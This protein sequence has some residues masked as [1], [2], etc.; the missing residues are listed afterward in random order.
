[1]RDA[2]RR[3]PG[4]AHPVAWGAAALGLL[5]GMGAER[6]LMNRW[7]DPRPSPRGALLG[8]VSGT[9]SQVDGPDGTDIVVETYGP[10]D[11]PQLVLVHGW[12]CT[13]RVWHELVVRLGRRWR[14]VTYD[15]PG[16]GRSTAPVSGRYDLD[17]L[18]DTLTRVID[19]ATA[20]GPLVVV[21]HSLGGM[22]VLNALRRGSPATRRRLAGVV[23]VSTLASPRSERSWRDA[24][25]WVVSRLRPMIGGLV[26]LL[27]RP[28]IVR[29]INRWTARPTD[30]AYLAA[31]WFAVGREADEEVID[32]TLRQLQT[33]D[34]DMAFGL[35]EAIVGVDED[36]GLT[37]MDALPVSL[38]GGTHD[39]VIPYVFTRHM[40]THLEER[41]AGPVELHALSGVGHMALLEA[42]DEL[43][44]IV[45]R[46]LSA[47][48]DHVA[49]DLPDGR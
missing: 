12:L 7:R 44:T 35:L 49:P 38:V 17:V 37:A 8:S 47:L 42:A 40:A 36:A 10:T 22:T 2:G 43:A 30:A 20:P 21:G 41:T 19:Q 26:T 9:R 18:G 14:I 23:L 31:R 27:R 25:I 45:E 34:T 1:M 39:R 11:A 32:F 46:H 48:D 4:A 28:R 33:A 24:G 6:L 13:G 3:R 29:A 15:Q 5:A 16:H